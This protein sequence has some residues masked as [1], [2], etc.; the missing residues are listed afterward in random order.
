MIIFVDG[1]DKTGKTTLATRL[2]KELNFEYRKFNKFSDD[3]CVTAVE[4]IRVLTECLQNTSKHYVFD[5]FYFPCDLIYGPLVDHQ[6]THFAVH[7]L[8]KN[9]VVPIIQNA[10][11]VTVHCTASVDTLVKRFEDENEEY[12]RPE[13]IETLLNAYKHLYGSDDVNNVIKKEGNISKLVINVDSDKRSKDDMFK[14]VMH[15]LQVL[16]GETTMKSLNFA[17]VLP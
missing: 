13:Q 16:F 12:V 2:A 5:R 8:Y 1:V 14:T 9:V 17:R 11:T 3:G 10:N 7:A 15:E 6:E 4:A